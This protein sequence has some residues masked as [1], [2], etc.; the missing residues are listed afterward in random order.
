MVAE[1]S[2]PGQ[3]LGLPADGPG[4]VASQGKRLLG[5]L[6][7]LIAAT[8]IGGVVVLFDRHVSPFARGLAG[9]VAYVLEVLAL[10]TLT[11]QSIGMRL[12][13]TKML[14]R[15]GGNPPL[16]WALVRIVLTVLPVPYVLTL[17]LDADTRGLHDQAAGT[18]VVNAAPP[19][20]R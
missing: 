12:V 16:R 13:H 5:T 10:T 20:P 7:D 9:T 17:L 6:L 2:Y 19:P 11:G 14:W 18:V 1:Q 3:R 15:D 4:S 8:L